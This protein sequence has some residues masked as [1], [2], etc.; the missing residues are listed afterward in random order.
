MLC[1]L[2]GV[3]KR[4]GVRISRADD[5]FRRGGRLDAAMRIQAISH[6]VVAWLLTACLLALAATSEGQRAAA[7]Q[8]PPVGANGAPLARAIDLSAKY[9]ESAC[10]PGGN[11]AYR[12]DPTSGRL[13]SSYNIVRHAGAIYA[14]AMFNHSH[15]DPRVV[16]AM[17]RAA[18][19]MRANYIAPDARSRAL[20]VWS[21]PPPARSD[22]DLGAAGLGLAAL[23]GVDE[24]APGS[25]PLAELQGLARF[26]A[27]LQRPDGSFVSKYRAD[28]GPVAD[29]QSLYYPGEAALGLISLYRLD[30]DRGWLTAAGR[31]LL[32]LARSGAG[33]QDLPADHWALIAT[34]AL[35]SSCPQADCPVPRGELIAHATRVC[36]RMLR[37]Q[38]SAPGARLDGGFE[39]GGRTTPS[40]T[41]LEGLLAALE[42]LPDDG[43]GRRARVRAAVDRGINFLLRAQ[44]TDGPYAGG[45][46]GAISAGARAGR[47]GGTSDI[48]IDYVQHALSAWLR[49]RALNSR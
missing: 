22:A 15:G 42:F 23:A 37:D 18:A 21:R 4:R 31:A 25:V 16:A 34:A 2:L 29:W 38:I 3:Q 39:A 5:G 33:A 17:V 43:T 8:S 12:L 13:S 11:F 36:D 47:S 41:R 1:E 35:L 46:P 14:L 49:Y 27:F 30:H 6:A 48:R 19:F 28:T 32:Y 20:A 9:L 10:G 26:V 45:M 40:A 24:A 44:I 7:A